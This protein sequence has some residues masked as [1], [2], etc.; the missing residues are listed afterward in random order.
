M[1]GD[2]PILKIPSARDPGD[3][4]PRFQRAARL[5]LVI[6]LVL[7][8]AWILRAFLPALIWAAILAIATWPL[9]RRLSRRWPHMSRS[10]R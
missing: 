6:G 1:T 8:G 9:Y 4:P 3:E 10:N 7:L 2:V 5:T